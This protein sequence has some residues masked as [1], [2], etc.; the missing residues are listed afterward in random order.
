MQISNTAL[1]Y[2]M[3]ERILQAIR[4]N[5]ITRRYEAVED[6]HL[7]TFRW[8]LDDDVQEED[9][10]RIAAK[11]LFS[12]WLASGSGIFHVSGKLGA[13]KSTLMKFLCEHERTQEL[14]EKWAGEEMP[15]LSSA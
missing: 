1:R 2:I 15:K 8:I 7:E 3:Q 14:L 10:G 6:A 12:D 5:D 9:K 13:G 4:F 11:N